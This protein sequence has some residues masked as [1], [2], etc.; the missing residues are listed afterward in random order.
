MMRF[1]FFCHFSGT[2]VARQVMICVHYSLD[3][4]L[5]S[6]SHPQAVKRIATTVLNFSNNS[7]VAITFY[8]FM[9]NLLICSSHTAEQLHALPSLRV[10]LQGVFCGLPSVMPKEL[11]DDE[12]DTFVNLEVLHSQIKVCNLLNIALL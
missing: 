7:Q 12:A 9:N 11:T 10:A 1:F 5:T 2:A 6:P 3:F 4:P 8:P